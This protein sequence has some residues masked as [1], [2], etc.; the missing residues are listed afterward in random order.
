MR[1]KLDQESFGSCN[2]NLKYEAFCLHETT[3]DWKSGYTEK[4]KD[5]LIK[6]IISSKL[7]EIEATQ[8]WLLYKSLA[9]SRNV[10]SDLPGFLFE[11]PRELPGTKYSVEKLTSTTAGF[12]FSLTAS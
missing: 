4:I 10:S 12:S 11:D 3:A 1:V 2:N 7:V 6:M 8:D 9:D 5:L